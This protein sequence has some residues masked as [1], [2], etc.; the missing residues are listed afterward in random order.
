MSEE[1]KLSFEQAMK[2]LEEIVEKLEEG[3]VPLEAAIVYFQKG[4]SL[5]KICHDKLQQVEK[6]MEQ[7]LEEDGEMKPFVLEEDG[8]EA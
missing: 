7:I 1:E 8:G 5:S 6:Q 4:M 2:D 3:D